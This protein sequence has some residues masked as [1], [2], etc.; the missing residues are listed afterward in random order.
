[1]SWLW[2]SESFWKV[3]TSQDRIL[4]CLNI[5][6]SSEL[7]FAAFPKNPGSLEI[8]WMGFFWCFGCWLLRVWTQY[9]FSCCFHSAFCGPVEFLYCEARMMLNFIHFLK[10]LFII[11]ERE[12]EWESIRGEGEEKQTPRWVGSPMWGSIPGLWDHDVIWREMLNHLSHPSTPWISFLTL[13]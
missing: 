13:L 8:E 1:M 10:I 6:F 2:N 12:N 9:C 3:M 7:C 4:G 5:S 11:R